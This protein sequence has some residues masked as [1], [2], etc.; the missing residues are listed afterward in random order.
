MGQIRALLAVVVVAAS[1]AVA[2]CS[3]PAGWGSC[4]PLALPASGG[5]TRAA[6]PTGP[7]AAAVDVGGIYV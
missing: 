5:C 7:T 2:G 4:E 1:F 3:G 6:L